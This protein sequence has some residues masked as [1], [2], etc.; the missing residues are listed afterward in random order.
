VSSVQKVYHYKLTSSSH[1]IHQIAGE[2]SIK[3]DRKAAA[4]AI[5]LPQ[6]REVSEFELRHVG[7]QFD[8]YID[9]DS[10]CPTTW[11]IC[12]E[13]TRNEFACTE[14]DERNGE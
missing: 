14:E 1:L 3:A 5:P 7:A 8:G 12:R 6:R 2:H 13:L 4:D 9:T 11:Y 10:D